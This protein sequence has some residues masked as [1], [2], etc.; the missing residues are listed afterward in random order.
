MTSWLIIEAETS[1]AS[2]RAD[3]YNGS[4][5]NRLFDREKT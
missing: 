5:E 1:A 2:A 3:G 4:K